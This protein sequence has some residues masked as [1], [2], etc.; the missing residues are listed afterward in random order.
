VAAV[1]AVACSALVLGALTPG[2]G[3]AVTS[4][5]SV[6]TASAPEVTGASQQHASLIEAAIERLESDGMWSQDVPQSQDAVAISNL[7]TLFGSSVL[8]AAYSSGM[9]IGIMEL[10]RGLGYDSNSSTEQMLG[11]LQSSLESLHAD[12][13]QMNVGIEALLHGQDRTD[14]RVS[15]T[16]AGLSTARIGSAMKSVRG[17]IDND[18]EPSEA[19]LSDIQTVVTMSISELGFM[20]NNPTTGVL[21]LMSAAAEPNGVSDLQ[22]YWAQID[23]ARDDYR[24]TLGQGLLTLD[25]MLVWDTTGTIESDLRV[26]ADATVDMTEAMYALGVAPPMPTH[27]RF[28]PDGVPYLHAR[29]S[30]YLLAPDVRHDS[31]YTD[32]WKWI[33]IQQ[34]PE[35]NP[36]RAFV[37]E[38]MGPMLDALQQKFRPEHN[39]GKTLQQTMQGMGIP[40]KYVFADGFHIHENETGG[41]LTFYYDYVVRGTL[42]EIKGN[43]VVT[44]VVDLETRY[45]AYRKDW[46]PGGWSVDQGQ[47]QESDAWATERIARWEQ[48]AAYQDKNWTVRFPEH[49]TNI[50]VAKLGAEDLTPGG[51]AADTR[52]EST[53]AAAFPD[54]EEVN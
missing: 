3:Q 43:E 51:F 19:N 37:R 18:L 32:P 11:D 27:E 15:Y 36:D 9:K 50:T 17:W 8:R 33:R 44:S 6:V 42:V 7:A 2:T 24:A 52:P 13:E 45:R 39:D 26:T 47:K 29:D 54:A 31:Q 23:A 10:L 12:I 53:L 5:E 46:S 1:S 48:Y 28:A 25:M 34:R 49:T 16:S 20:V 22:H 21:P 41:G 4:T 38:S 40:T 35:D 14:F 30:P